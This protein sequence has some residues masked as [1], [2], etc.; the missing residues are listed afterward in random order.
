MSYFFYT[1]FGD[2][3]KIYVDLVLLVN[4]GFDF[5]LLFSVAILLRRQT[6]LRKLIL[7]SLVGSVTIFCMFIKMSS[8]ILFLL[9]III[10]VLMVLIVFGYNN[11]KYFFNNLFYLYTSSV[12]LGGFMYFL[13]LQFSLKNSGLVFYYNGL[14]VNFIVL[15]IMSP[16]IL[17]VYVKQGIRLKNNYSNYYNVD[18]YL[19]D[20]EIIPVCAFLD[21]GNKL[22]DPYQKRPIILLNK[23]LIDIDYN[24][25]RFVI[26][27]YDSLNNHGLLKCIIPDKMFIQGVGF[28]N[29]FLVGISNEKI[30]I[31]GVDCILSSKL[32]ERNVI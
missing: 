23:D 32:L 13:S 2:M 6:D 10:S 5:I 17:Y 3:M 4:F 25:Y 30:K 20:N 19:N 9:K 11:V 18:I 31:D 1:L 22:L 16:I 14:S 27:P 29:N 8:F 28:K 24:K 12:I 7:G 15:I 21:T 26:V